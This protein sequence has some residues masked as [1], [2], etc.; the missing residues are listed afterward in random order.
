MG[1]RKLEAEA[2][3]WLGVVKFHRGQLED[4]ERLCTHARE[5]LARTS[6]SYFQVQNLVRGLAV[7]AL[8]RGNPKLAERWLQ[9]A[10]PIA[11]E[12][13]GWVVVETYRFLS[14]ALLRQGRIDDAGRLASFAGRNLPEEDL[15]ARASVL[16]ARAAVAAAAGDEGGTSRGYD[17]AIMLL[18]ELNMPVE[19]A[20][21]RL[22]YGRALR[23]LNRS[24]GA[25][26]QLERAREALCAMRAEGVRFEV[27]RELEEIREGAGPAGPLVRA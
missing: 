15:Y 3:S 8:A 14:D 2:T 23:R 24:D 11:L 6:D 22:A 27:E 16:L 20:E 4:A 17:Q 21:S 9:E 10:L 26:I 12:I 1:S 13:G 5:W 25:L 19:V 7:F 18:E